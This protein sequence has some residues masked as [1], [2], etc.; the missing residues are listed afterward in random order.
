MGRERVKVR[1]LSQALGL[2]GVDVRVASVYDRC[3]TVDSGTPVSMIS[4][5]DLQEHGLA[6]KVV[7][8]HPKIRAFK[9]MEANF[10]VGAVTLEVRLGEVTQMVEFLVSTEH[11]NTLGTDYLT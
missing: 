10:L 8:K 11:V 4:L 2:F 9:D 3:F 5:H 1:L 6:S 7:T